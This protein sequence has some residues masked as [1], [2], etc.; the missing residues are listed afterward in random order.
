M[1]APTNKAEDATQEAIEVHRAVR[2]KFVQM[3]TLATIHD[4]NFRP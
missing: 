3:M 4:K 2:S 1:K